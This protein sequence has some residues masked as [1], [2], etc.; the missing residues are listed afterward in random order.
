MT[1]FTVIGGL[2]IALI[3]L[4]SAGDSVLSASSACFNLGLATDKSFSQS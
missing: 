1:N 4:I 3:E 2:S